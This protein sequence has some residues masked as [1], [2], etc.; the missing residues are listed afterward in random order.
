MTSPEGIY[1]RFTLEIF[2]IAS[3]RKIQSKSL[4]PIRCVFDYRT[5]PEGIEPP[6]S[7]PKP[8][9]LS[10][11]LRTR[12]LVIYNSN[13]SLFY[14]TIYSWKI[15]FITPFCFSFPRHFWHTLLPSIASPKYFGFDIP[16][17]RR[18]ARRHCTQRSSPLTESFLM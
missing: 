15:A 16:W 13:K 2:L 5:S 11:I 7:G 17:Q 4:A 9:V 1:S 8:G 14:N 3:Q 6:S 10:I 18:H 12:E